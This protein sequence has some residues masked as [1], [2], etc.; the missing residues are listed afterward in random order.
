MERKQRAKMPPSQRAKQFMPFAAVKGL[1]KAIAEQNQL[2]NC[3][4]QAELGEEQVR[5]ISDKLNHLAKGDM[6]SACFYADGRYNTV[7]G[8]VEQL[9]LVRRIIRIEGAVITI[10]SIRE[11]EWIAISRSNTNWFRQ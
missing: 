6:V 10:E 4:E 9:D 2:L 5:A 1:E 7:Q 8:K 3:T 11:L